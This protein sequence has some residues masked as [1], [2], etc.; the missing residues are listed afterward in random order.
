[1]VKRFSW[2]FFCLLFSVGITA[3]GGGRQYNSYKGLVMAG[4][5]GWFNTPDDGSGRGWHHYNGPK[6]FR[7]GSCSIDFWPEVSEYKKL[8]KT[9]FTFEDGKP[10]SVFSSYD[11]STVELHFKWMN[12]YGLDGVFM[13][14]FVSE[15][16][17]ESGLKHFNKVLNSAMKAANKYE[18][19]IC[20]MYDLS[21]MKPGEEGLLLKDIA[22]IAR[23][24]SI[25]DHV[26][27]PSYL[28][29]NGKPLVTV[30]GVGF[31]DNRR[32]G[33]KEAER[34]IDGLKLQ[35]FSVMLGVPTQWRELK[36]D[37]ESDPH[38]HQLIR[39]CDIVMP[40]FVGRYN[41]NTYPKF[42]KMVEADIQWAKKNQ[43]DYAPLV[44]PGFSWG[45]MKGQD[46]NSFI[47]RNKGSFLWKQLMGAIRAGAEMIYVAMFDEVD[48]GTAIFKCAKKVPVGESI[49][50]PVEE[51]VE[52]DHYLKLVG[53]AGKILRKEKAMAFDTSLNPSAPN[54]FIRH[55]YTA[56]PSAHV[57]KD[58]R[59]YVYASHDIAPPHGCDLMDRYHVFSTDDMVH[60]TDHGEI[61]NSAQVSW[62]RKE[63]GFM[64]APDCAYKNGTYYFY[65]PHP[66]GTNWNDSWKIGVATSRKPA[67]GFKVKGY[68]EGM[69][70]LIDP[71]VF[72]DDD[73]QAYIYNGGGGLCKGGKLKDN[74]MELDGPMQTMEGL[75]DFHEATW[76]HK[77]NG[78]YYLSYSDN[79]DENWN[80]GVKGDNRMR[81]AVS[82]S[83]LGPWESKGIY[84]EP[85]DSYTNHGSIV[86]FKGQW[87]A[88]YHNSALSNHDWLRSICVDKLYHNPDGTIKLVKQ[89]KSTPITV[90]KRYPFRNPQLSIEQR[91]DDLVSRLTLEE[92]VR[93]MLNNAPAIK[94]LGIPAYNWWNECLHGVGRTKYHVTV[95]PQAIGMA[96]SWNDVL[97]KEVASS[98]ADEGRAIYNDAQKRGDYS[99]YH[100]L[101]YWTPNI[102][103]FRDP[104][105]GR[106]QET[107]GED[108]YLTSKIGKAFVLGLQGDDPCYLKASAC[109]KHYAVHSGPEKNRHSFNSDVSTYD[110]WDTYLPAFRTLVVDANVSG[111]MCA[112]NA[113]KGQPCCGNDLLMQS[114]LRDKWN[115][116]G[117]VTSDCGAIDDIFNHHKAHPDAA[118]AAADAVFHG[119]DLDCG[120]SAYLALVKAVKNGIITEKQLDVSVKRLFT[121]RFRLGLF[122][123]AEQV[124]YAHI[125]ISVLELS[126]IHI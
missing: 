74:M 98:I 52:S 71:C 15:I 94:R 84:M 39:K 82:D 108:P 34:I 109:A 67:E 50:I 27:N 116:K 37:T 28:Y 18:R 63:G 21:G 2:L 44:F 90:Q 6:G 47:P 60:W 93:Q 113:F 110:L 41:E 91:V 23:Q 61:L 22:E 57:W 101:T 30:W 55:M 95:F 3:K 9:E 49:F 86:E 122:D 111:V 31:N 118:T 117:Y 36:G 13:Q 125:P 12:Q 10:A 72:V 29:H 120:Q 80:D 96:A 59:L 99:Q 65:F 104:R 51:E 123:P 77:Y 100:A 112:Y 70:P 32:Y 78:K 87:Y 5:Q 88:F 46:H 81:Y 64:W 92:K 126:L 24:Y 19:A 69:D 102:N 97:M 85:T 35:G 38:L 8:Y 14:R 107:Y 20:V 83:P 66:S 48:E 124:D 54:P 115:F 45:N 16:R 42:Q 53:E 62:G 43:V 114:I 1:M 17:N 105:W 58:G 68:I 25:K 4:Y 11:E 89:T 7:P 121:I 40:W 33:L 103:I 73:G 26:K 75:E 106:G 79:H 56:D 119:T 76:I